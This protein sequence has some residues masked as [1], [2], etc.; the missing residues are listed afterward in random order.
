MQNGRPGKDNFVCTAKVVA[1]IHLLDKNASIYIFFKC[2][3]YLK[4]AVIL[5]K[6]LRNFSKTTL[7]SAKLQKHTLFYQSSLKIGL[8]FTRAAK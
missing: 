5:P 7:K 3:I 1:K 4:I 8:H 2:I 6:L